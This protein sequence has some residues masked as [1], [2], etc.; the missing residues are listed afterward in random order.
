MTPL[1]LFIFFLKEKPTT[2]ISKSFDLLSDKII[3]VH[4]FFCYSVRLEVGWVSF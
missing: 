3:D 4:V 2:K 1:C